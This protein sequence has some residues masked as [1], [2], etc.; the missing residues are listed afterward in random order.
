MTLSRSL[1]VAAGTD[2]TSTESRLHTGDKSAQSPENVRPVDNP[3]LSTAFPTRRAPPAP[4]PPPSAPA[5]ASPPSHPDTPRTLPPALALTR[6]DRPAHS[7]A[8]LLGTVG[9]PHKALRERPP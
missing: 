1:P 3:G 5:H 9:W 2:T 7:T 4:S 6:P 8:D